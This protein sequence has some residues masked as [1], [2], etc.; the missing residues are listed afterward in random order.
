MVWYALYCAWENIGV[1]VHALRGIA[2]TAAWENMCVPVAMGLGAFG[3]GI[4][5]DASFQHVSHLA[6]LCY[7]HV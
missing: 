6:A 4:A 3:H 1:P 5:A 2:R 7:I